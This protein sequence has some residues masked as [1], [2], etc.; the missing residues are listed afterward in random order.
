MLFIGRCGFGCGVVVGGEISK[1]RVTYRY[2]KEKYK[3]FLIDLY[4]SRDN[5]LKYLFNKIIKKPYIV[6]KTII[7]AK[8]SQWILFDSLS[9]S[10]IKIIFAIGCIHKVKFIAIGGNFPERIR[11]SKIPESVYGAMDRIFVE[12]HEMR[13]ILME[14]GLS[15][16]EYLP[17]YKYL[18]HYPPENHWEDKDVLKL[19]YLGQIRKEKGIQVLLD[20]VKLLNHEKIRFEVHLYGDIFNDIDIASQLN[21]YIFYDGKIDLLDRDDNY[22]ILRQ[23]DIFIFP[24]EWK[25]EGLSGAIQDALALGKPIVATRHLLNDKMVFDGENGYLFEKGNLK[26]LTEILEGF[27]KNQS[28]IILLGNRSLEIAEQFRAEIV[29]EGLGI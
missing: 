6:L 28:Q 14:M 2:C 22:D 12:S 18:P 15:N 3:V 25:G 16:V 27:Y 11:E 4:Y 13:D 20:A 10:Y 17:N 9:E 8:L 29:L 26:H 24:T 19:F 21:E 1:N 23:Y 7:C 5:V